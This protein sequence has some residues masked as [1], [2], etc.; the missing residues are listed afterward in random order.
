MYYANV[1]TLHYCSSD[2]NL[3]LLFIKCC[4]QIILQAFHSQTV[5]LQV[6]HLQTRTL[7]NLSVLSYN[8]SNVVIHL[9]F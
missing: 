6:Q 3:L 7:Q 4:Y 8:Y 9:L 2:I 1:Y 5:I